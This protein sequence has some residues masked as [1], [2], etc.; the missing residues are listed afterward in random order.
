MKLVTREKGLAENVKYP[1]LKEMNRK[2]VPMLSF[3]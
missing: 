3:D 2:A 1:S